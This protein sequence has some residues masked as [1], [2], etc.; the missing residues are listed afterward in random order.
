MVTLKYSNGKTIDF[1]AG[2]DSQYTHNVS[3]NG[4]FRCD[5]DLNTGQPMGF[6]QLGGFYNKYAVVSSRITCWVVGGQNNTTTTALEQGFYEWGVTPRYSISTTELT[7]EQYKCGGGAC[8][9]GNVGVTSTQILSASG[10]T[11]NIISKNPVTNENCQA[12]FSA[13]PSEEW[14]Y[15]I[16]FWMN[17][18]DWD[19]AASVPQLTLSYVIEYDIIL[20]DRKTLAGST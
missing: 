13:S 14:S 8:T 18:A 4:V 12:L 3:G 10:T 5:I 6:D 20:M 2:A 19:Y 11:A 15:S 16:W 7:V 17:S 1:T 9:I